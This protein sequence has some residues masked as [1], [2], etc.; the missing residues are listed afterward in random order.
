M[1][2]KLKA[3]KQKRKSVVYQYTKV[4]LEQAFIY[5]LQTNFYAFCIFYDPDFFS[6][7][8]WHLKVLAKSLQKVSDG[9]IKKLA[10]SLPPRAGK[11]YT[12]SLWCAWL[13]GKGVDNPNTS[14]MR[15]S[16]GQSIAQ[17]FS[18]DVRFIIQSEKFLSVFPNVKLKTDKASV[19]DWA[20]E[21]S[22]QSTYFCSGVGGAVTGKGCSTVGISDDLIKNLED[23]LSDIILEKTWGWYLSTH[24]SRFE[25]GCPEVNIATRWSKKDVIG[26]TTELENDWTL[27]IIP[28]LT[29]KGESFCDE[30]KSTSEYLALKKIMDQY[31]WEAEYMQNPIESK[32]LLYPVDELN[33]FS[34]H[35]LDKY[36]KG[37]DTNKLYFDAI[38][39]YTDIAD[40]GADYLASVAAAIVGEKVYII[41]VV[42]TQDPIEVTQPQVAAMIIKT[43]Q[44]MHKLESNNGGKAFGM[45]VRELVTEELSCNVK[46]K[47]TTKNKETRILM[48][49]GL[50]KEFFYFRDDYDIGSQY[51]NFMKA[52]TS[53]VRL[54][55]NKHDDAPDAV[56]GVAEMIYKNRKI[57]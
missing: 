2:M 30:I 51:D 14:I 31:I 38:I 18:Y 28:A 19:D 39:G 27:V 45:K 33:R 22:A 46:W 54:G 9:V 16:Y 4:A 23:A 17:K 6:I 43:E 12:V 8:K 3:D 42:F 50:V 15:N 56:T 53:Y 11:S 52:L 26:Q 7:N 37:N 41:D 32:G 21:G 35:E 55:K 5:L 47:P 13:I 49:A 24:K 48:K 10:V 34:M 36:Y 1:T 29:D 57:L 40:E 20:I 25:K 44:H